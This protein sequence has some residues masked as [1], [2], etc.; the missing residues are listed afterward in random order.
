MK[1]DIYGTCKKRNADG[2]YAE[3]N[4]K[5]DKPTDWASGYWENLPDSNGNPTVIRDARHLKQECERRD[6]LA[7]SLMKPKSQGKG[8]EMRAPRKYHFLG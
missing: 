5:L 2:T 8:Y 7:P 4:K 3:A 6:V 1:N